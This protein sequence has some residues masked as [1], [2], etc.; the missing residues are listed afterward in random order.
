MSAITGVAGDARELIARADGLRAQCE[1][2]AGSTQD[3]ATRATLARVAGR[4]NSSVVRPLSTSVVGVPDVVGVR[5]RSARRT[6]PTHYIEL[7]LDATRLRVRAAAHRRCRRQRRRCRTSPARRSPTTTS[8][9]KPGGAELS[10]LLETLPPTIQSAPDGPYLIT[11]V[12]GL[13]D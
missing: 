2:L 1:A 12:A 3:E 10:A 9:S 8:A 7:A 11:N 6:S 13:T 5:R 4:L